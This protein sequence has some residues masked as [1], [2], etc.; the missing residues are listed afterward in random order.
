MSAI[1]DQDTITNVTRTSQ[2]I[3]GALVTGV[4]TF[5]AVAFVVDLRPGRQARVP[6]V[7]GANAPAGG[8]VATTD[9]F[10]TYT[11]VIFAAVVLPLSFVLPNVVTAQSLRA[12]AGVVSSPPSPSGPAVPATSPQA[13]QTE[14]GKL[15]ALYSTNLVIGAAINEGVV[16]AVAIAYMIEKNPIALVVALLLIAALIARFPTA[17][18]V[19]RW[20]EQ[21]REKLRDAGYSDQSSPVRFGGSSR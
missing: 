15:A 8:R 7:A 12:V 10:I 17:G 18:R 11:A 13:P 20:I 19:E 2:I 5:V 6:A 14:S 9:S 16:F 1:S 4:L 21:Q 3:V